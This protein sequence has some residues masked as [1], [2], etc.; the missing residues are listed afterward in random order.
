MGGGH[1]Q[2][3]RYQHAGLYQILV[4]AQWSYEHPVVVWHPVSVSH[5]ELI[6]SSSFIFSDVGATHYSKCPR[7][8]LNTAQLFHFVLSKKS[9]AISITH[10]DSFTC[11]WSSARLSRV[12]FHILKMSYMLLFPG[13]MRGKIYQPRKL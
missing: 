2:C 1:A 8:G 5:I 6:H 9:P 10:K 7:I 13:K 4:M 11:L 12:L 3:S